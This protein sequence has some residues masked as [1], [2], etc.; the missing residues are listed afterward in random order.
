MMNPMNNSS[1]FNRSGTGSQLQQTDP[2]IQMTLTQAGVSNF[3]QQLMM[4]E[5]MLQQVMTRLHY[6]QNQVQVQ[7]QGQLRELQQLEQQIAQ[8]LQQFQIVSRAAQAQPT[9]LM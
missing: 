8:T 6:A 7:A 3:S 4:T 9:V 1:A 2:Q 5:Q